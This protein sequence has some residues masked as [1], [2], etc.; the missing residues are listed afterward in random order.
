MNAR[1]HRI[2][3]LFGLAIAGAVALSGG[4]QA[5]PRPEDRSGPIAV[6]ATQADVELRAALER[7]VLRNAASTPT[8]DVF[9]RAVARNSEALTRPNDRTGMLGV[10]AIDRIVVSPPDAFERAVA[11]RRAAAPTRPD[12]RA[13]ARGAGASAPTALPARV[14]SETSAFAWHDAT[15]GAG[16][17]FVALML[18]AVVGL[19]IRRAR[20]LPS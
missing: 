8:P 14:E 16:A 2:V 20:V 4:A 11:I 5:A 10:G 12:D 19:T 17:V 6:G 9:E 3:V 15:I 18:V 13:A 7:A 1:T